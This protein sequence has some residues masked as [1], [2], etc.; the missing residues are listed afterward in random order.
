M[1]SGNSQLLTSYARRIL[2][3][4]FKFIL[5]AYIVSSTSKK[6]FLNGTTDVCIYLFSGDCL[7]VFFLFR[8]FPYVAC[9]ASVASSPA[10][11][12]AVFACVSTPPFL[13]MS[14]VNQW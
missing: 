6:Y 3:E 11:L 10:V 12:L 8:K 2:C 14:S 9:Q 7:S 1:S 4:T 13:V 5:E